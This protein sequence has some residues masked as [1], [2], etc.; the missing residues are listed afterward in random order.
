[1]PVYHNINGVARNTWSIHTNVNGVWRDID[2]YVNVNGVFRQL[3]KHTIDE[4][5]IVGFRMVYKRLDHIEHPN[6]P[7]LKVNLNLPVKMDLTGDTAGNMD[8]NQKGV[9]FQ[10]DRTNYDE[11][12]L[13]VYKA[14]LYAVLTNDECVNIGLTRSKVIPDERIPGITPATTEVWC[15]NKLEHLSI[16]MDG[17]ILYESNGYAMDGWNSLFSSKQFLDPTDYPDT[18]D[19]KKQYQLNSY[20]I[21]P[22]ESRSELFDSSAYIGIARDMHSDTNNMVGSYGVI[23]HTICEIRVNGVNKPF[24]F[25][26]YN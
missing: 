24:V 12:G 16:E 1:M 20:N 7:D 15:T 14:D 8:M 11:E 4:S 18:M 5:D 23:D 13:Y 6:H 26:I 19:Y 10:Y 25:E 2:Q 22:I 21:L 9:V 3:Y 17:Y